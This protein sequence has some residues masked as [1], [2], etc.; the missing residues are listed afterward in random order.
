MKLCIKCEKTKELSEFGKNRSCKDGLSVYCKQCRKE[1]R[2]DKP[3]PGYIQEYYLKNKDAIAAKHKEYYEANR[4]TRIAVMKRYYEE[5]KEELLQYMKIYRDENNSWQVFKEKHPEAYRAHL[6]SS[7][8]RLKKATPKCLSKKYR[9]EI[10]QIYKNRP[11]GYH[12]DHII[13]LHGKN[14]SGLHV[15]W[16]L[17]Y[18]PAIENL[19]KSNKVAIATSKI[20]E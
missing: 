4:E 9:S 16:N 19:K 20:G 11:E 1:T 5:N 15:P 10:Y 18:L 14:I 2:T 17:Q 13:P 12:V 6:L 8:K 3:R 7:R